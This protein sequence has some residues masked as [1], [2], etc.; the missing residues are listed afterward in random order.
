MNYLETRE[1]QLTRTNISTNGCVQGFA[2]CAFTA[3]G[4]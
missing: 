1:E 4:V 2:I 3:L